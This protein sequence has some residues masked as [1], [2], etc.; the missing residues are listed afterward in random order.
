MSSY[1]KP[2]NRPAT[3]IMGNLN[4]EGYAKS[5]G[6]GLYEFTTPEREA[7]NRPKLI[8]GVI[9]LEFKSPLTEETDAKPTIDLRKETLGFIKSTVAN[10]EQLHELHFD[11]VTIILNNDQMN[12]IK[13]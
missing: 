12:L 7:K 10:D 1:Q 11:N 8:V 3:F 2:T 5:L 13:D 9:D 4:L 6:D